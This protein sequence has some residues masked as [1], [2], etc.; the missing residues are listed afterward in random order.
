MN[1]QNQ[2]NPKGPGAPEPP[3][4]IPAE[5]IKPGDVILPPEREL[6]LW[7]RRS[8]REKGLGEEA[9]Q[10]TVAEA[11]EGAPDK[12]G[13]WVQIKAQYSA[14][15]CRDYADQSRPHYMTFKARPGTPWPLIKSCNNGAP[16]L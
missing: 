14:A 10:L 11:I 7:M 4:M 1:Q 12:R 16:A 15:W 8:L 5:T 6:R 3:A 13:R 2:H 9:L